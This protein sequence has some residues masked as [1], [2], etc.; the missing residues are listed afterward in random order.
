[1]PVDQLV[2]LGEFG[3]TGFRVRVH[4]GDQFELGLAEIGG[5]VRVRERRAERARM[6]RIGEHPVRPDA[7]A[8]LFH[9]APD[10]C[11]HFT[12]KQP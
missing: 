7:Q 5:D 4:A 10:A 9:A 3:K 2:N 6:R 8:L 11:E 1:V 12:R